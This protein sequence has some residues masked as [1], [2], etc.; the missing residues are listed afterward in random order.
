MGHP[1]AH[2][3]LRGGRA[4]ALCPCCSA[5]SRGGPLGLGGSPGCDGPPPA[6]RQPAT[7]GVPE[8]IEV[9]PPL[10]TSVVPPPAPPPGRAPNRVCIEDADIQ[11]YGYSA[12]CPRCLSM[13]AG[14]VCRG[15]KHREACHARI[16]ARLREVG[17]PRVTVV[18]ARWADRIVAEGDP[19]VDPR[20]EEGQEPPPVAGRT[21]PGGAAGRRPARIPQ[22]TVN[23]R[24]VRVPQRTV[25]PRV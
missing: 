11:K 19:S 16:E 25:N 3:L 15:I 22:R 24:P 8:P 5:A 23:P 20:A 18:D 4:G 10:D 7:A 21:G 14:L 2:R 12:R 6:L 1:H 9:L 13:R 17:D